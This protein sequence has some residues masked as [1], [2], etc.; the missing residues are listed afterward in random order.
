MFWVDAG[1]ISEDPLRSGNKKAFSTFFH[2]PILPRCHWTRPINK[3]PGAPNWRVRCG[4][5]A[6]RG[7][8]TV[9]CSLFR[10]G[11]GGFPINGHVYFVSIGPKIAKIFEK[12]AAIKSL[13]NPHFNGFGAI[14]RSGFCWSC[15]SDHFGRVDVR[16]RPMDDHFVTILMFFAVFSAKKIGILDNFWLAACRRRFFFGPNSV[17]LGKGPFSSAGGLPQALFFGQKWRFWC[18]LPVSSVGGLFS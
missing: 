7:R 5:L 17:S 6:C 18:F 1:I 3:W 14:T 15:F 8:F 12:F 16:F 4:Y 10:T 2:P 13:L 11:C 9:S